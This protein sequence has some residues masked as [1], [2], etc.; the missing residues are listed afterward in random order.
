MIAEEILEPVGMKIDTADSGAKAI[1]LIRENHY[2][3][4]FMDYMMPYMDGAEATA[5]VRK[6]AK[7][8]EE[9]GNDVLAAYYQSVPII[10]LTGDTSD[11]T[12][13]KFKTAGINDFTE[14][15]VDLP[16][17]KKLLTKWLPEDL[18]QYQTKEGA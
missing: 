9:S 17:L 14:K 12:K 15:P 8:A 18:I 5:C 16:R 13:E 4:V 11:V 10:A 7:E 1:Q 2:H 6:L 3:A